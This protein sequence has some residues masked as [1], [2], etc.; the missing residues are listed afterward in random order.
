[1]GKTG[2]NSDKTENLDKFN[3]RSLPRLWE[4]FDQQK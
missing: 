4:K 1:M 2:I 3:E